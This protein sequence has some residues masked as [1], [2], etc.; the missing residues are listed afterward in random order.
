MSNF[1]V[2]WEMQTETTLRFHLT[3]VTVAKINE[4]SD[5]LHWQTCEGIETFI[6]CC[7]GSNLYSHCGHRCGSFSGRWE[8]IYPKKS[9]YTIPMLYTKRLLHPQTET[10]SPS[11]SLLKYLLLI[12]FYCH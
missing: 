10:F 1:L 9:S 12:H 7:R 5:S 11:C 6:Y 3:V 8:S 4:T 2:I